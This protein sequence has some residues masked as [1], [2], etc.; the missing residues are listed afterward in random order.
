MKKPETSTE[1]K[2]ESDKRGFKEFW[3]NKSTRWAFWAFIAVVLVTI[4]VFI[5]NS[6][7]IF[8]LSVVKAPYLQFCFFKTKDAVLLHGVFCFVHLFI[9]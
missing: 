2:N 7:V 3:A 1:R 9:Y 5:L 6:T 4:G 8:D